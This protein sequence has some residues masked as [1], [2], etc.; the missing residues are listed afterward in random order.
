MEDKKRILIL[1][2]DAGFGHR[3][4]ALAL[5]KAVELMF[6]DEWEYLIHN[7]L[8]D[9]HCPSFLRNSQ[10][11]YDVLATR[12]PELYAL[13]Y[14]AS[15]HPAATAA[16][17][18][19]L[20]ALLYKPLRKIINSYNP[21]LIIT[22]YPMYMA[23]VGAVL[24]TSGRDIPLVTVIT[25]L[26]NVH[27]IWFSSFSDLTI[28]TS[29]PVHELALAQGLRHDKVEYLGIPV[30]PVFALPRPDKASLQQQLG[31]LPDK[32]VL[33]FAGSK[34]SQRYVD[35]ARLLDHTGF[36][37]QACVVCGG[38][39]AGHARAQAQDWHHPTWIYNFV[40]NLPDMM[41][42]SDLV[43]C[44]AGGLILSESLA[45]GLPLLM[46]ERIP[47]Q[48]SGNAD[49]VI[50]K[51]AGVM[52]ETPEK[53]V[54]EFAHMMQDQGRGLAERAGHARSIG[55][56]QAAQHI[57]QAGVRLYHRRQT[58]V[59]LRSEANIPAGPAP[60]PGRSNLPALPRL[61]ELVE[62]FGWGD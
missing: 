45:A 46:T 8:N 21:Q 18:R 26:A 60:V 20:M 49:L 35:T 25:D 37:Y 43:V 6:A 39:D 42:A 41:L 17:E 9:E 14:E 13:G 44:K 15:D 1:S 38:D 31:W 28:T 32:P 27:G 53:L 36:D 29:R 59:R 24:G 47:G 10:K 3:S 22:C 4:A 58:E 48:E 62:S 16:V 19:W 52:A 56:P 54:E 50:R 23:P 5:G 55:K 11:D 34:R 40:D 7:P 33:L 57:V 30:N 61:M 2:A 12:L 51:G